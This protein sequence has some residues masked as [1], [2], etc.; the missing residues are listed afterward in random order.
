VSSG[1]VIA[2]DL[3]DIDEFLD[4]PEGSQTMDNSFMGYSIAQGHFTS[5]S[6]AG[7]ISPE[8]FNTSMSLIRKYRYLFFFVHVIVILSSEML[9]PDRL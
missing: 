5:D 9:K 4:T 3:N 1:Q 7:A 6:L 2:Q 8:R